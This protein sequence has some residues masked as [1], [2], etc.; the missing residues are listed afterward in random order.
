[1]FV[2]VGFVLV[3]FECFFFLSIKIT[4]RTEEDSTD[5]VIH[6]NR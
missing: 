6:N 5:Q 3:F 4:R 2:I 1:M